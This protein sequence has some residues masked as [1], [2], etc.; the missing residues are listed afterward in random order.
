VKVGIAGAKD[1]AARRIEQLVEVEPVT[2]CPKQK[3]DDEQDGC[4][5]A[6]RRRKRA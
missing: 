3:E 2:G 1:D 4:V 6:Q 5:L